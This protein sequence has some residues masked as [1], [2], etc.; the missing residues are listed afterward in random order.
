MFSSYL[1]KLQADGT[2]PYSNEYF[3]TDQTTFK[4]FSQMNFN[5]KAVAP[6]GPVA[7]WER[8][9]IMLQS[10]DLYEG[11][12]SLERLSMFFFILRTDTWPF[13]RLTKESLKILFAGSS[14]SSHIG[15]HPIKSLARWHDAR[16]AIR[17]CI[18]IWIYMALSTIVLP[19][20]LEA[21]VLPR[22]YGATLLK[23]TS[24]SISTLLPPYATLCLPMP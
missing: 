14:S 3:I 12:K 22:P 16:L 10:S 13:G 7:D 6:S 4:W 5:S 2:Q 11:Y 23:L 17:K 24:S 21:H 1:W 18:Y 20:R 15:S 8:L 9:L 19:S